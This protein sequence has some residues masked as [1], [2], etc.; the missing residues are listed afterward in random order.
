MKAFAATQHVH[1]LGQS[2]RAVSGRFASFSRQTI[3]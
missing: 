3:A 1:E 2:P